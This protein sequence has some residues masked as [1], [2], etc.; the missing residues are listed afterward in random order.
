MYFDDKNMPEPDILYAR[1]AAESFIRNNMEDTDRAA[2]F[3]SSAT[4][5]QQ[6]TSNKQQLLDSLSKLLSHLRRPTF[7]GCPNITPYQAYQMSLF[8]YEHGEAFDLAMAEALACNACQSSEDCARFVSMK[9]ETVLSLS[10]IFAQDS[11]GV[12]GDVIRYLGKMPGRRTLIMASSGFFSDSRPVQLAQDKMIDGALH[13]GIV[14]NT[15]DA[16]GLAADWLGGDPAD[17]P[18]VV[19]VSNP[20]LMAYSDELASDERSVSNDSLAA[21]AE[22]TGGKFFHNSNDLVGGLRQ[23]AELPEVAYVLGFSPDEVK[24]NGAL[25]SLKVRIPGQHDINITARP[26]YFAPTKEQAAPASKFQKLNKEVMSSDTVT[27]LATHVSTESGKLATGEAALR[28]IA[29]VEGHSLFFKKV[30]KRH[31]ERVIFITALFDM[32]GH[33]LAGTEGVMDLTL[34]DATRAQISKDGVSANAT[35][36]APPGSYRLR[37]VMQEVVGGR[38]AASNRDVEIR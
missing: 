17:G 14:I 29:H 4:V 30:E 10:E 25:H 9:A 31:N 19:L 1:K 3:T 7:G 22:G 34:K 12:L 18:P 26:S 5:T 33:Y 28:V 37:E 8:R 35:L 27:E 15:L 11:L 20:G 36:Q 23:I 32:Q 21:L 2:I 24:D 6:F 13:S 38:I 16:K